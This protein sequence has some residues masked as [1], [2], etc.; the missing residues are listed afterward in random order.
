MHV[1][2][3]LRTRRIVVGMSQEKLG[4]QLGLTFQ[5]VQKYEKGSNRISAS[6]LWQMGRILGVPVSFFFEDAP[7]Q[8]LN[9]KT[10]FLF[11]SIREGRTDQQ[12]HALVERMRNS[13]HTHA[14][15]PLAEIVVDTTDVPAGWVMEGGD[16]LPEPGEEAAWLEAHQ[17]QRSA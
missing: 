2:S 16:I 8:P 7:H 11:G 14:G 3:R 5:Q 6:R 9:G 4:E 1:G 17:T 13:I 15:V 10:V 12:K